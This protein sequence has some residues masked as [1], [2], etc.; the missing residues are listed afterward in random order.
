[1]KL[2]K[3]NSENS[4]LLGPDNKMGTK[5]AREHDVLFICMSVIV[6]VV[7]IMTLFVNALSGSI[8]V[9][10]GWFLNGTGDVSDYYFLEITPAGWTFSI[11]AV[12]YTFQVLFVLY[13]LISLCRSNDQGPVYRNPPVINSLMLLL[14]TVNLGLNISWLFLWDRE[15]L[16]V[17]LVVIALLPFTLY[18]FLIINHRL[19]NKSGS[20]LRNYHR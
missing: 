9:D 3:D 16:P 10:I 4:P 13:L 12:I 15:L 5:R 6:T 19:V 14:Y 7:L 11:W 20:N 2:L 17:A 18:L 8:G 1:M